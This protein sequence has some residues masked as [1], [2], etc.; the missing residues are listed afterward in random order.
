MNYF[1]TPNQKRQ[2][3]I[4]FDKNG[5]PIINPI[6]EGNAHVRLHAELLKDKRYTKI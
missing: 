1:D 6:P 4:R 2:N 5:D 3:K